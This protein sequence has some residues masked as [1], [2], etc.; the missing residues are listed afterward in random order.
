MLVAELKVTLA[1]GLA[2]NATVLAAV[3]PVP[4]MATVVFPAIGPAVGEIPVT[5]GTASKV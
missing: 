4:T 5:V 3:K 2:P 1:A